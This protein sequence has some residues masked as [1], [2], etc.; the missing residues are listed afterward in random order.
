MIDQ[1]TAAR[2]ITSPSRH[3]ATPVPVTAPDERPTS[4]LRPPLLAAGGPERPGTHEEMA[5]AVDAGLLCGQHDAGL[6]VFAARRY[7][8]P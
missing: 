5:A 6:V 8:L 3:I 7:S 4:P 1:N 2:V